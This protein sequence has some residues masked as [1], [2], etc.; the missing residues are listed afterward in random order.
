[1][2]ALLSLVVLA[3]VLYGVI[4]G[5]WGND[6]IYVRVGPYGS[7]NVAT[8]GRYSTLIFRQGNFF[9]SVPS[10]HGFLIFRGSYSLREP[11][12]A[13]NF[14]RAGIA[15]YLGEIPQWPHRRWG[16]MLA[17]WWSIPLAAVRPAVLIGRPWLDRIRRRRARHQGLCPACGLYLER[18][19]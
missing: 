9:G 4:R 12:A 3:V 19:S 14:S 7:L 2:L 15:L 6:D 18:R 16:L 11:E 5:F 13:A 1:M 8:G 10:G 17:W